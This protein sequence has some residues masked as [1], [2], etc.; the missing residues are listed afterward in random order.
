[1]R[2]ASLLVALFLV[3]AGGIGGLWV[4]RW[5][6]RS[7][8]PPPLVQDSQQILIERL[9]VLGRLELLRYQVRDVVRREWSY[10]VPL[11]HSRLLLVVAG[12]ALV[13]MDFAQVQIDSADWER[14]RLQIRL[15]EPFLC[16]V[17][18][19]PQASQV[20]DADF[21]VI[22]WW[23]G[24][25]AERVREALAA[26]Q[27]TLRVRLQTRFPAEAARNQAEHLLRRLCE[28]MGWKQVE[29]RHGSRTAS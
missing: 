13:C 15:P 21:S 14:R 5:L 27:E 24:G 16:Q 18:I 22:E 20:Y 1:M 17:R 29:F 12:E 25:E 7:P 26:A 9:A 10:S 3:L 11:A 2:K 19:D 23:R 8:E 4:G 6:Y 28:E